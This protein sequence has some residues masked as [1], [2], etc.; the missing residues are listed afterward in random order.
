MLN[1]LLQGYA[2]LSIYFAVAA[3]AA[4]G[5]RFVVKMPDELF[6]KILHFVLLGSVFV[7][8]FSFE[9]WWVSALAALIFEV[10]VYPALIVAEKIKN[11]SEFTTERKKVSLKQV[12]FLSL[13]CL[14]WLFLYAGDFSVTGFLLLRVFLPGVWVMPLPLLSESSSVSIR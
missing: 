7:F 9:T 13:R 5:M 1:E 3:S 4:L 2:D 11:F 14:P 6:R 12:S 10:I 8:T